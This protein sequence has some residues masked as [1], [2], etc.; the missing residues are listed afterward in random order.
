MHKNST[1]LYTYHLMVSLLEF[2]KNVLGDIF[3]ANNDSRLKWMENILIYNQGLI[4]CISNKN[5]I[6]NHTLMVMWNPQCPK[7][8]QEK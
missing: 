6:H 7:E 3:G 2:Y 5:K 8:K 4:L 1:V